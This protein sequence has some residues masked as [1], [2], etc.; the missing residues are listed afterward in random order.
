[1]VEAANA[2]PD[3]DLEYVK[4]T[5]VLIALDAMLQEPTVERPLDLSLIPDEDIELRLRET[6]KARRWAVV[7]GCKRRAFS[8]RCENC[9]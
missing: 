7:R 8:T 4:G 6:A 2:S 1:M 5:D 9:V 3:Y